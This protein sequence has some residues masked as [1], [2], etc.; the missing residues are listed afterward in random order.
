MQKLN[1][2]DR[3]VLINNLY[4]ELC[5]KKENVQDLPIFAR[6][7]QNTLTLTGYNLNSGV[8][9]ALGA[10][11]AESNWRIDKSYILKEL[12]LDNNDISDNDFAQ[13]LAGISV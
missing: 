6:I 4:S 5:I 7:K 9:K 10:Y 2:N 12:V 8:C 1:E 13:I 3:D 11:L